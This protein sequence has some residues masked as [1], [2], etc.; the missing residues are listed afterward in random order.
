MAKDQHRREIGRAAKATIALAPG[1]R[2]LCCNRFGTSGTVVVQLAV[3]AF[4]LACVVAR[5]RC[6][7]AADLRKRDLAG[8]NVGDKCACNTAID[9]AIIMN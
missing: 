1:F 3:V 7:R 2:L 8:A 4:T 5:Q 9:S 6:V